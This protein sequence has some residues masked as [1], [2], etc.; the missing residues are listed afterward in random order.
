MYEAFYK[1]TAKP[2]RLSPDPQF[3]YPS[4]GHK[5]AL[6]Y[7]LYGLNQAEG[8]V[9][10]TGAPGTGKTTLAHKLLSQIDPQSVVV[11]HLASTQIEAEDLLRLVAASFKLRSEHVSKAG[12]LKDIES[13][14]MARA[15]ERKRC[16]LV[17]DEAQNLPPRSIEELR[18]LSN[19]QIGNK[20]LMQVFLLGQEQFRVMLD[21]PHFEQLRQRV[22]ADYHLHPLDA[23]ET[24]RY[25]EARLQHVGW[26]N[27][28]QFDAGA[29]AMIFE[30][31]GGLP[32]RINM[33]CD[34][35]FLYGYLEGLHTLTHANVCSV[36]AE[37][38]NEILPRSSNVVFTPS[39]PPS[40]R[41]AAPEP[42]KPQATVSSIPPVA[43]PATAAVA[44]AARP[45]KETV[46]ALKSGTAA[47]AAARRPV[48][49]TEPAAT[50][51]PRLHAVRNVTSV[52][53]GQ[54][55]PDTT[56][57]EFLLTDERG[58]PPSFDTE[59]VF[60]S[61]TRS[62]AGT[63]SR[64]LLMIVI[65]F[66]TLGVLVAWFYPSIHSAFQQTT[67]PHQENRTATPSESTDPPSKLAQE[68]TDPSENILTEKRIL[69]SP[70]TEVRPKEFAGV[71]ID[72][73][74]E[75]TEPEVHPKAEHPAAT[76]LV[77]GKKALPPSAG[78]APISST[79]ES[80]LTAKP[81]PAPKLSAVPQSA[82]LPAPAPKSPAVVAATKTAMAAAGETTTSENLLSQRELALLVLKFSRYYEEG[83]LA[84]FL[85]LFDPQVRTEDSNSIDAIRND[86]AD[87]FKKTAVRQ[88]LLGD[89]RWENDGHQA[90]G[91]GPFEVRIGV[92]VGEPVRSLK[93]DITFHIQKK[94]TGLVIIALYHTPH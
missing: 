84:Q 87:L 37:M 58:P 27:D 80:K 67:S 40:E 76:T 42:V 49:A 70:P 31:T 15:R 39:D 82:S 69:V 41:V 72:T 48:P 12:L 26:Q 51:K 22:I 13:F 17:V 24:Q 59:R 9:V 63:E 43:A 20:A 91:T 33:F 46:T 32:R 21:S 2:F 35:L 36:I 44:S 6:S 78:I 88:I 34:R 62:L 60:S 56:M 50:E 14:L 1:L 29:H 8:F 18:M 83:N 85:D 16:L 47:T 54:T 55:T 45:A 28:P 66:V 30:Y 75:D 64:W 86:Y 11:A 90:Q 73:P 7:L 23:E 52:Q 38:N 19:F 10:I 68:I 53:P 77:D 93:G 3:F 74:H 4:A 65:T 94:A 71:A 57:E 25:I 79:P 81:T 92:A 89:I 5:R 61:T